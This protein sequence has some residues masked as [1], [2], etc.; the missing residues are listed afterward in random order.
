MLNSLTEQPEKDNAPENS[1]FLS[2]SLTMTSRSAAAKDYLAGLPDDWQ[3]PDPPPR[4]PDMQQD[5]W[6]FEFR[7]ILQAYLG[8]RDNVLIAGGGYLRH[9]PRNEMEQ[10]VPDCVV[11]FGVNPGAI[12]GRNGY[13]ISHAGKPPDFVLEVASHSTGRR[14]Y[15][16]KRDGYAGYGVREYWRFDHTGGQFH[17]AALAG[18]VL[19]GEEYTPVQI[20]RE[21]DGLIWGHSEVLGLDLCWDN[22]ALRLRN[23]ATGT[24]LPTPVELQFELEAAQGRAEAAEARAAALEAELR[25]LRGQ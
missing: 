2:E 15:T 10:F 20:N 6:I 23:P 24:F 25:Q 13:V 11:A 19:N 14:D 3:L 22:G 8:H 7:G 9:D 17:D 4:E 21:A 16:V 18:D 1:A 5:I 12:V